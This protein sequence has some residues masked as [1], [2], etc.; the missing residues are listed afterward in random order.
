MLRAERA[1]SQVLGSQIHAPRE[2]ASSRSKQCWG[3]VYV[4]S[5]NDLNPAPKNGAGFCSL[6]AGGSCRPAPHRG[7]NLALADL[8][9]H[10]RRKIRAPECRR[11]QATSCSSYLQ[12]G[13][14]LSGLGQ[15]RVAGKTREGDAR[16]TCAKSWPG[17]V[18]GSGTRAATYRW[19]S[20]RK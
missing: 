3:A 19:R 9:Q 10:Q 20:S 11:E 6:L 15:Q 5:A 7:R 16:Q 17:W 14:L 4:L 12:P 13:R 1:S 8:G 18:G 2:V